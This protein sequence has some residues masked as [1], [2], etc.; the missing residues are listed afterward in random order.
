MENGA[1]H[2]GGSNI[3]FYKVSTSLKGHAEYDDVD[4]KENVSFAESNQPRKRHECCRYGIFHP[5]T[6]S[7]LFDERKRRMATGPNT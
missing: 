3:F 1:Q 7:V 5:A 6:G 4:E 2:E